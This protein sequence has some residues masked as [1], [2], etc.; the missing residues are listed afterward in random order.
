MYQVARVALA[1]ALALGPAARAVAGQQGVPALSGL[2]AAKVR[3]GP[4][5]RG[6]LLLLREGKAWRADIAGYSPP[7]RS[8]AGALSFE[9]PGAREARREIIRR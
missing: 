3:F 8:K 2:W 1:A 5:V 9:L 6:S 4:D 7:V